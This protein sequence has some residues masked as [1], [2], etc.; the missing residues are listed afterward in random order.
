MSGKRAFAVREALPVSSTGA[1]RLPRVLRECTS[2]LVIDPVIK[3]EGIF[4][5]NARA[6][7]V[8]VMKEAYN[9]AQQYIVFREANV[10]QVSPCWREGRGGYMQAPSRLWLLSPKWLDISLNS[11][12]RQISRTA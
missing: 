8:E 2:F 4:R 1:T 12:I 9:R 11:R 6:M 7:E 10:S 3:T 5:I